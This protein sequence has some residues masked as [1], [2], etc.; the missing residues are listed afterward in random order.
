MKQYKIKGY[1]DLNSMIEVNF[2]PN[3]FTNIEDAHI[4]VKNNL[5]Y[6][7]MEITEETTDLR[8]IFTEQKIEVWNKQ[9]FFHA[10]YPSTTDINSI[11]NEIFV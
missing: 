7:D 6:C 11:I 8:M 1:M 10:T 3:T 2:T 5:P 4:A 9:P